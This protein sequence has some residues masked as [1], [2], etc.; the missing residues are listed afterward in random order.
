[1][2]PLS[3][4]LAALLGHAEAYED[5][6]LR[7]SRSLLEPGDIAIDGGAGRGRNSFAMAAAVGA[8][9]RV[10]ACE[11]IAWLAE[12]LGIEAERRSLPQLAVRAVALAAAPGEAGFHWVR[13][14][15]AYSGLQPRSYPVEPDTALT[16]VTCTT[17]DALLAGETRRWRFAKLDLQGGKLPALRGAAAAIAAHR[18]VLVLQNARAA[19]AAA[20]GYDAASFFG[21]FAGLGYRVLDL[22]GRSFGRADWDR[23]DIPWY[24]IAVPADSSAEVALRSVLGRI[25][26]EAAHRATDPGIAELEP[27]LAQRACQRRPGYSPAPLPRDLEAGRCSADASAGGDRARRRLGPR[28]LPRPAAWRPAPHHRERPALPLCRAR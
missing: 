8:E 16:P 20:Y 2:E 18:P 7:L 3:P 9:G 23:T 22:F 10:L 17:I 6:I 11:P 12:R 27:W 5:I 21:F 28:Q 14:A 19:A 26:A 1:M 15:D 25:L 24:A 4:N 13:N